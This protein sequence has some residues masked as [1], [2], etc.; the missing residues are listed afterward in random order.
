[1]IKKRRGKKPLPPEQSRTLRLSICFNA[2]EW[3]CIDDNR[4]SMSRAAWLRSS[5][6]GNNECRPKVPEINRQAYSDLARTA[7]NLNQ[8]VRYLNRAQSLE[9]GEIANVLAELRN[10]LL[11]I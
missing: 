3:R 7:A 2:I 8:L 4:G 9:V 11:G 5:A 10:R 1:M 6:L